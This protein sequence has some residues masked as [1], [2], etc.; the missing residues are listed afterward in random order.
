MPTT[1][2]IV[3]VRGP[4][5]PSGTI[6][7]AS[8]TSLAYGST[9]TVTLGGT[10]EART[11]Q[12]NIP[13]GQQGPPGPS[14]G[15]IIRHKYSSFNAW[16][17][18]TDPINNHGFTVGDLGLIGGDE[19]ATE[20]GRVYLYKGANNGDTG[21]SNAWQF[22]VDFSVQG[23]EGQAATITLDPTQ[24]VVDDVA[25]A[26]VVNNGSENAA[27]LQFSIPR[28]PA[29]TAATVAP[30][31]VS[32]L[33]EGATPTVTN[34]GTNTAAVFNFGIPSQPG[35]QGPQG[36]SVASIA[37]N[38][39]PNDNTKYD[40]VMTLDDDPNTPTNLTASFDK[41]LA[42]T[43]TAGTAS[44]LAAGSTPTV[45]NSGTTSAA[46]FDFGIPT[47]PQGNGIASIAIV[48]DPNDST[49]WQLTA[50]MDDSTTLTP[51]TFAKP[52]GVVDV[53]TVDVDTIKFEL[54][55]GSFTSNF[56]LPRGLQGPS[57]TLA[58]LSTTTVASGNN[59]SVTV[60]GTSTFSSPGIATH[61]KLN[62]SV[63]KGRGFTSIA[64][65]DNPND[66]TQ[67][68]LT[69]TSDDSTTSTD[70]V[71]FDKPTNG[72]NGTGFTGGSYNASTGVVTFTSN[73]GLGFSTT[74]LRGADGA[75]GSTTLNDLDNVD[76]VTNAPTN[77]QTLTYDG[78]NFVPT[79]PL[80]P[81]IY[82]IALG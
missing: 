55:D 43:A 51:V 28:G 35:P 32:I 52:S 79:T 76:L 62:F 44:V 4:Q 50:T 34:T 63:P 56:D 45:T 21:Q 49:N 81:L 53:V 64:I 15:F 2:D 41:P 48:E 82:A 22:I 13:Q 6:T 39:N 78:T 33:A 70:T 27:V 12:F 42:A 11:M 7:S 37:V 3:G 66:N 47:G 61:A 36:D 75:D 26:G 68:R 1:F 67:Y 20:Y 77:G 72:T 17:A 31:T 9:P 29:G 60:D 14:G 58:V 69:F 23:I 40:L 54:E 24:L 16:Q 46:V 38:N 71:D 25:D 10:P 5:G 57:G 80:N 30:G 8:A 18:D 19:T 74:D 73:D 65:A 59:A